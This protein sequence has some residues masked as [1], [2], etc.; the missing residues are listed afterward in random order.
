MVQIRASDFEQL[1]RDMAV[2]KNL[3]LYEGEL[4]AW[5]KKELD[6]SR[7]IPFSQGISHEDVKKKLLGEWV[8]Q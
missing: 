3:I 1:V 8:F 5:A 2:L 4:S 6:K 7:K